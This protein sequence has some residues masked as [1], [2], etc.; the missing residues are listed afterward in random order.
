[1]VSG[2]RNYTNGEITVYWRPDKCTHAARCII[3]LPS[4]FNIKARPWVNMNGATTQEIIRV[5]ETCPSGALTWSKN[6]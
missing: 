6:E 1:M 5:V 2:N 3:G 4:V